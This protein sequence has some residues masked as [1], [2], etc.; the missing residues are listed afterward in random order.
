VTIEV[1]EVQLNRVAT[2]RVNVHQPETVPRDE[3]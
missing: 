3:E 1:L 2:V